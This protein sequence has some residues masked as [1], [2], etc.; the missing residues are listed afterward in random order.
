MNTDNLPLYGTFLAVAKS[1]SIL[2]AAR[3]LY[4]SQPAVSKAIKKLEHNLNTTLFIRTSKGVHLTEDG[5]MLYSSINNAFDYIDA[6]ETGILSRNSLG[7]GHIR[8][9]ASTTLCKYVLLPY[10]T[11]YTVD[12]PHISI[13]IDCQSTGET[14]ELLKEGAI[15]VGLIARP[16]STEHINFYSLG[17]IHDT[18]IATPSYIEGLSARMGKAN[19]LL[20]NKDNVTRQY[21]D[22]HMTSDFFVKNNI[23][24]TDNMNLLIDFAKSGIGIGCAI[25]EFVK[26][27][28]KNKILIEYKKE[29]PVFPARQI[30]IATCTGKKVSPYAEAF[31]DY[32]CSNV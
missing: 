7:I 17:Y 23:L 25:R 29:L 1:G 19:I 5:A 10:L 26:E 28:L 20:L 18:F 9:G 2:K 16:S 32:V 3:Q 13:S 14:L 12:H 30:G 24:E 31:I 6:G 21:V 11:K 8:I 27:E 4:I 15:D 22:A